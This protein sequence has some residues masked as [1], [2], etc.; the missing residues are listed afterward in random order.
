MDAI[1]TP[2]DIEAILRADPKLLACWQRRPFYLDQERNGR[3]VV[4][5]VGK[6]PDRKPRG[7]R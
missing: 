5:Y 3:V 7:K 6:K 4:R 2:F 1:E